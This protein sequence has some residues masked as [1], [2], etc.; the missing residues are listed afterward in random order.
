MTLKKLPLVTL[1]QPH[2][3]LLR[4][5]STTFST[6]MFTH[7]RAA[8]QEKKPGEPGDLRAHVCVGRVCVT[9]CVCAVCACEWQSA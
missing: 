4:G 2:L 7:G 8:M 5:V 9:V 6:V 1:V 3:L